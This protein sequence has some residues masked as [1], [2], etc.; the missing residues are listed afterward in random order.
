M[1]QP[2]LHFEK[3]GFQLSAFLLKTAFV[4]SFFCL[5]QRSLYSEVLVCEPDAHDSSGEVM[6]IL[7]GA[8][9][10]A[11]DLTNLPDFSANTYSER[12]LLFQRF[13]DAE[14]YGP[15]NIRVEVDQKWKDFWESKNLPAIED[16]VEA[17]SNKDSLER[18]PHDVERI[19]QF[20]YRWQARMNRQDV[21]SEIAP[22]FSLSLDPSL[23][24]FLTGD[25]SDSRELSEV[26]MDGLVLSSEGQEKIR[27]L[28]RDIELFE[29]FISRSLDVSGREEW[30]RLRGE[31]PEIKNAQ[32]QS[33]ENLPSF[34]ELSVFHE[35][36]ETYYPADFYDWPRIRQNSWRK[37]VLSPIYKNQFDESVENAKGKVKAS[38]YW[39]SMNF[40]LSTEQIR[41]LEKN[42]EID[43]EISELDKE[44][45]IEVLPSDLDSQ[46]PSYFARSSSLLSQFV[47]KK[48]ALE[49][50]LSDE[51]EVSLAD[52]GKEAASRLWPSFSEAVENAISQDHIYVSGLD[53]IRDKMIAERA[54]KLRSDFKS[55]YGDKKYDTNDFG[56]IQYADPKN[57][58]LSIV[59]ELSSQVRRDHSSWSLGASRIAK[60]GKK[61]VWIA[62]LSRKLKNPI[63]TNN[64]Y[65][66]EEYKTVKYEISA[67]QFQA[68]SE[69]ARQ[70]Q[71][72]E[73]LIEEG[74]LN[75]TNDVS[76]LALTQ[77][78]HFTEEGFSLSSQALEKSRQ[79]F[80]P[81]IERYRLGNESAV[82]YNEEVLLKSKLALQ[83]V[84]TSS[85]SAG[86]TSLS[87]DDLGLLTIT[88]ENLQKLIVVRNYFPTYPIKIGEINEEELAEVYQALLQI[89]WLE[90]EH[91]GFQLEQFQSKEELQRSIGVLESFAAEKSKFV[92]GSTFVDLGCFEGFDSLES[93]YPSSATSV[94][95]PQEFEKR[96]FGEALGDSSLRMSFK[97]FNEKKEECFEKYKDYAKTL[98]ESL[99]QN[100]SRQADIESY[101][102]IERLYR[103]RQMILAHLDGRDYLDVSV[104][105]RPDF[106]DLDADEFIAKRQ[107]M[108]ASVL[109]G[110]E[111]SRVPEVNKILW[112]FIQATISPSAEQIASLEKDGLLELGNEVVLSLTDNDLATM[113]IER[114]AGIEP[115][116]LL[117]ALIPH[118]SERAN[119]AKRASFDEWNVHDLEALSYLVRRVGW[120]SDPII[121]Y[122]DGGDIETRQPRLY[123]WINSALYRVQSN[124]DGDLFQDYAPELTLLASGRL[125]EA[126]SE[127]A[128]ADEMLPLL[129]GKNWPQVI[130]H[131]ESIT[132]K[133]VPPVV[134]RS[135]VRKEVPEALSVIYQS[136]KQVV[137]L[138]YARPSS[139]RDP[140]Q[141]LELSR[142]MERY[143]SYDQSALQ[144]LESLGV[145][146][147]YLESRSD[148]FRAL[149]DRLIWRPLIEEYLEEQRRAVV[150]QEDE[151]KYNKHK[152]SI[153][154][155]SEYPPETVLRWLVDKKRKESSIDETWER[156]PEREDL[157]LTTDQRAFFSKELKDFDDR[158]LASVSS[159]LNNQAQFFIQFLGSSDV[160]LDFYKEAA[161]VGKSKAGTSFLRLI[162]LN[163][164]N[165][166]VANA[167]DKIKS[168][169]SKLYSDFNKVAYEFFQA[170]G[171]LQKSFSGSRS[172]EE[173]DI[174]KIFLE[175][176]KDSDFRMLVLGM[177]KYG[178][179]D[180]SQFNKD[181]VNEVIRRLGK[182]PE[183]FDLSRVRSQ[184][185]HFRIMLD[186]SEQLFPDFQASFS[187]SMI[188]YLGE[189]ALR[190]SQLQSSSSFLDTKSAG[191]VIEERFSALVNYFDDLGYFSSES[192]QAVVR[193]LQ[194]KMIEWQDSNKKPVDDFFQAMELYLDILESSYHPLN[195]HFPEGADSPYVQTRL[196]AVGEELKEFL[197]PDGEAFVSWLEAARPRKLAE[198][199][200]RFLDE[201]LEDSPSLNSE[202]TNQ[203][204]QFISSDQL[205]G[206]E[207]SFSKAFPKE[208]G[209]LLSLRAQVERFYAS[210]R[211]Q[212]AEVMVPSELFVRN[213]KEDEEDY[214]RS[215]PFSSFAQGRL[216][217]KEV[218]PEDGSAPFEV[219]GQYFKKV[220]EALFSFFEAQPDSFYLSENVGSSIEKTMELLYPDELSRYLVL[221]EMGSFKENIDSVIQTMLSA[222]AKMRVIDA[223]Q[224]ALKEKSEI[225][226]SKKDLHSYSEFLMK[227]FYEQKESLEQEL[228]SLKAKKDLSDSEAQRLSEIEESLFVGYPSLI[229][230]Q[231]LVEFL[232]SKGYSDENL[233]EFMKSKVVEE[234]LS[235]LE[236]YLAS[237]RALIKFF[238]QQANSLLWKDF[239]A[240]IYRDG[241]AESS[242]NLH[243]IA[244]TFQWDRI[245]SGGQLKQLT[246][247]QIVNS[248]DALLKEELENRYDQLSAQRDARKRKDSFMVT[249]GVREF[250]GFLVHAADGIGAEL[251]RVVGENLALQ[252][253][254]AGSY[255]GNFGE[256]GY[257]DGDR[258][259]R[260][261]DFSTD[262]SGLKNW[263]SFKESRLDRPAD[264][265]YASA[266]G[267]GVGVFVTLASFGGFAGVRAL[268]SSRAF[269]VAS[270]PVRMLGSLGKKAF[271]ESG[272]LLIKGVRRLPQSMQADAWRFART[273]LRTGE[274]L[275]SGLSS[276]S[277]WAREQA[278][279]LPGQRPMRA[280]DATIRNTARRFS[281][282]LRQA[283]VAFKTESGLAAKS[284][285]VWEGAKAGASITGRQGAGIGIALTGDSLA[286]GVGI[287]ALNSFV[288]P[289][290]GDANLR[291][292]GSET[293][294]GFQFMLTL[295]LANAVARRVP[296]AGP[297][298]AKA[299]HA[300]IFA[301]IFSNGTEFG[302]GWAV[303]NSPH[304]QNLLSSISG[305]EPFE[306][307]EYERY[308]NDVYMDNGVP[309]VELWQSL[310]NGSEMLEQWY[311][312]KQRQQAALSTG[313]IAAF[314]LGRPMI[315]SGIDKYKTN[316]IWN[317]REA[318]GVNTSGNPVGL[319]GSAYGSRPDRIFESL[320][321]KRIQELKQEDASKPSSQ[322]RSEEQLTN[323][324]TEYVKNNFDQSLYYAAHPE[325]IIR[326]Y[327]RQLA[328]KGADLVKERKQTL[329]RLRQDYAQ[330]YREL[331]PFQVPGKQANGIRL[332]ELEEILIRFDRSW[333]Q[334]IEDAKDVALV[335]SREQGFGDV[336]ALLGQLD[337]VHEAVRGRMEIERVETP[338]PELILKAV[339][340]INPR[341]AEFMKSPFGEHVFRQYL[342]PLA[343][344]TLNPNEVV[345]LNSNVKVENW[346][347]QGE[348]GSVGSVKLPFFK[349]PGSGTE[350]YRLDANTFLSAFYLDANLPTAPARRSGFETTDGHRYLY[351]SSLYDGIIASLEVKPDG[352]QI[353]SMKNLESLRSPDNANV[354][355]EAYR[356]EIPAGVEVVVRNN[357][358]IELIDPTKIRTAKEKAIF[359]NSGQLF[360][361]MTSRG[362]DGE[363]SDS[364]FTGLRQISME[365]FDVP[366]YR[367]VSMAVRLQDPSSG[368]TVTRV[369]PVTEAS[370]NGGKTTLHILL[371]QSVIV[372]YSGKDNAGKNV[373]PL[374][375]PAGAE[376]IKVSESSMNLR[377]RF[378]YEYTVDFA[379]S[380]VRM[381]YRDGNRLVDI[382]AFQK[383]GQ[384]MSLK[385]FRA[386][387]DNYGGL[388]PV[389][390][391]H[392][393]TSLKEGRVEVRQSES[394][395]G[396]ALRLPRLLNELGDAMNGSTSHRVTPERVM[397]L[398]NSARAEVRR[399]DFSEM[400]TQRGKTKVALERI[401]LPAE[402]TPEILTTRLDRSALARL[403]TTERYQQIRGEVQFEAN[404]DSIRSVQKGM[405]KGLGRK[406][407]FEE[408]KQSYLDH[409]AQA[410]FVRSL[411]AEQ[412]SRFFTKDEIS[413]AYRTAERLREINK[414]EEDA[415]SL[416]KRRQ[417]EEGLRALGFSGSEA[418]KS[419]KEINERYEEV[420]AQKRDQFFVKGN[421]LVEMSPSGL[422]ADIIEARAPSSDEMV[423]LYLRSKEVP[424]DQWRSRYEEVSSEL[425]RMSRSERQ[426]F[427]EDV[428]SKMDRSELTE[429]FV[430]LPDAVRAEM[431]PELLE[432]HGVNDIY[433]LSPL[434]AL[435]RNLVEVRE[436]RDDAIE[437]FKTQGELN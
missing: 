296:F 1:R 166:E 170:S 292:I 7:E 385:D 200:G 260:F 199:R 38:F 300:G 151:Q 128:T 179:E 60:D 122:G 251:Y 20:Y 274:R 161:Q 242:R 281:D 420:L 22:G 141:A 278:L 198:I 175:V 264:Y 19:F 402:F 411:S 148:Q 131:D 163:V 220:D 80:D 24:E 343:E 135:L 92:P 262:I 417:S 156:I 237:Q 136:Q 322:R 35:R 65:R 182:Q 210:S 50:Q 91:L 366:Q 341:L 89:R 309:V 227:K 331:R 268:G 218:M 286:I 396:L 401:P 327:S 382:K 83:L 391:I 149:G 153:L 273:G 310:P 139:A 298:L 409:F 255:I 61:W 375:L 96:Q 43:E 302:L 173:S 186:A 323:E 72:R 97:D 111:A 64:S 353:L 222:Q 400:T 252:A 191:P 342:M 15:S 231:S 223:H 214:L 82:F 225:Y 380:E 370:L 29:Y 23:A 244:E 42:M 243:R 4:F 18:V 414:F 125:Q 291:S 56:G 152:K 338:T 2:G 373:S 58:L 107:S 142:H 299:I 308:L 189:D 258:V 30:T 283:R 48:R 421:Q 193:S 197:Q 34:E 79:W 238:H 108:A 84:N 31:S 211:A 228:E 319:I 313:F 16:P 424:L 212:H 266:I 190:R 123:D 160:A 11:V 433:Y 404:P 70:K 39:E 12:E 33:L 95:S 86:K 77:Q 429:V 109:G 431:T 326:S 236:V 347:L 408:A 132:E 229:S 280:T 246:F 87:V 57:F 105:D 269:S 295:A 187:N 406:V 167:I 407:T 52:L 195:Q 267:D 346:N 68:A 213:I 418:P 387:L 395:A 202:A 390:A 5:S 25:A 221:T 36:M 290:T 436:R 368:K 137:D 140:G 384:E 59:P 150:T 305:D 104:P 285:Y 316:K 101:L 147:E 183:N 126:A 172:L 45:I 360:D 336:S 121:V 333:Y 75:S 399:V 265:V 32:Y 207:R 71:A 234:Q 330:V 245:P 367:V 143:A 363:I 90:E 369:M 312:D 196:K 185:S 434:K 47:N 14:K 74:L 78:R 37:R 383:N 425:G 192:D 17:L 165:P 419:L 321:T 144:R 133:D 203:R 116:P 282:R 103:V 40:S 88:R 416:V 314:I 28:A 403:L 372:S 325:E 362:F 263:S 320:R 130:F 361:V 112:R 415:L 216:K 204:F 129:Y 289:S 388:M 358:S 81:V 99:G 3:Q 230:Q 437:F 297:H 356:V 351:Q 171:D 376:I 340:D 21:A 301:D 115:K 257:Y 205:S 180:G 110:P 158:A 345:I 253:Y 146:S 332:A 392:V 377:D 328:L 304:L 120:E 348:S 117:N 98:Q 9:Q 41:Q 284:R 201:D 169:N 279:H 239:Q 217:K 334:G 247:D 62:E 69:G 389:E 53:S 118:I 102:A 306:P 85:D 164:D 410:D 94:M 364:V 294:H 76:L 138:T 134:L 26:V 394:D 423:L 27:K 371:N 13:L 51:T 73:L 435:Y 432:R 113:A 270:Q 427:I 8:K 329:E 335:R 215:L 374:V 293:L 63:V 240:K 254:L 177:A 168:T 224:S 378:G 10:P 54:E 194:S 397:E 119:L 155:S 249:N 232:T 178:V 398:A 272:E 303:Q 124:E 357:G 339:S 381:A 241:L 344:R 337:L 184:L 188:R 324:A 208:K 114:T 307:R 209:N 428:V 287:V 317:Q 354:R 277:R 46:K 259:S 422:L 379:R 276:A 430:W 49:Y 311:M 352:R 44:M 248:Y 275:E 350:G 67:A 233:A 93:R 55:S 405:E 127:I 250:G 145:P 157:A 162:G 318:E 365:S 412:I 6:Q 176:R 315:G 271:T 100:F 413:F 235:N 159:L 386:M 66:T 106:S 426:V 206:I 154:S 261:A 256:G 355:Q 174:Q 181:D 226:L 288:I 359:E 219:T 349:S 393:G